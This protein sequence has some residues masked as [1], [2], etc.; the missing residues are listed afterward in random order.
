VKKL[1]QN[2]VYEY[3]KN[4][5]KAGNEEYYTARQLGKI[6]DYGSLN[7]I[8]HLNKLHEYGFVEKKVLWG[9]CYAFRIKAKEAKKKN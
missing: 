1:G 2:E 4:Q 7:C 8:R 5:R 6:L 9:M 3:L